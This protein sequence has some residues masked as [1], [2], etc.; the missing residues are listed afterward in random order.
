MGSRKVLIHLKPKQNDLDRNLSI[1]GWKPRGG[2]QGKIVG[3]VSACGPGSLRIWEG[4]NKRPELV[5]I[6]K[7][8]KKANEK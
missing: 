7:D 3:R 6:L 1:P 5:Y 8:E 2:A 4:S